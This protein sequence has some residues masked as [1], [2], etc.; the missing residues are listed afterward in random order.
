[1]VSVL[2]WEFYVAEALC[3]T[4]GGCVLVDKKFGLSIRISVGFLLDVVI[5]C[6]S[7]SKTREDK[8]FN[9][10]A[11]IVYLFCCRITVPKYGEVVTTLGF[12]PNGRMFEST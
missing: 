4:L 9:S 8:E 1:M 12:K 7:R 10:A 2:S 5:D 6:L 3:S 11:H